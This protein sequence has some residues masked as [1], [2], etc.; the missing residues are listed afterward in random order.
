M[1]SGPTKTSVISELCDTY[2]LQNLIDKPTCLKGTTPSLIDDILVTNRRKYS[3]VLNCNCHISD[4][5]NFIGAA[6]R[7]FA[8]LRKPRHV[9]CRSYKNFNDGDFCNAVSTAPFH[10][11]EN[12][13]DVDDMAWYTSKLLN[14]VIDEH[15]PV[16]KKLIKQESVPYMNGR[17][18]KAMYQRNMARNKFR[19]YG[20]QY[21]QE[22]R[23]QRILVVSLRKKSL[24][25]YFSQ[26]CIKK[27]KTFWKTI[28]PFMTNKH[29]KS[30]D[31]IILKEGDNT[32][33]NNN[34][35]CEI[36]NDYFA[37]I[38]S[39]IGFEDAITSVEDAIHKHDS[40]PS[41]INIKESLAGSTKFT[42]EA[43]SSEKINQKLMNIDIKKP[44]D[45]TTSQAKSYVWPT[46]S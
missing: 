44:P 46:M 13:D 23:R 3:G 33:V 24:R 37:N 34:E 32:I 21:W 27:D 40:H 2:G 39:S 11:C 10:V 14:D 29:N 5:H 42:F 26:R 15:A 38:A 36:F 9:Y 25:N 22:N 20:K 28:S 17:L 16:K 12:F 8:P 4:V 6:T 19:K 43:V 1:N 35:L 41:V 7:R 30:G 18:R 45:V 31:N